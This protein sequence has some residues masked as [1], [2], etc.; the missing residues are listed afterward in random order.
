MQIKTKVHWKCTWE[1]NLRLFG[2]K[3]TT[4]QIILR[5]FVHNNYNKKEEKKDMGAKNQ[6]L[7][8]SLNQIIFNVCATK[9]LLPLFLAVKFLLFLFLCLRIIISVAILTVLTT[10][11]SF[12]AQIVS[13]ITYL[14]SFFEIFKILVLAS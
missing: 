13:S 6:F 4:Y 14:M 3:Y 2:N 7:R 9:V 12:L 11:G 5:L 10:S 1:F 8:I